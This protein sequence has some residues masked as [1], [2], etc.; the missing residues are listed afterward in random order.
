M[1]FD[2]WIPPEELSALPTRPATKTGSAQALSCD[3]QEQRNHE[4]RQ[5]NKILRNIIRQ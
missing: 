3:L 1:T 4:G 5:V 2:L